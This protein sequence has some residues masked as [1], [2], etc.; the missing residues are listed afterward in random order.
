[1]LF[2]TGGMQ[3]RQ[4]CR[5]IFARRLKRFWCMS[6]K[7]LENN[8]IFQ[9]FFLKVPNDKLNAVSTTPPNNLLRRARIF[10]Q[11]QKKI[12]FSKR[13]LFLKILQKCRFDNPVKKFTTKT[14]SFFAKCPRLIK[15]IFRKIILLDLF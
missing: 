7:H 4:P 1:M 12:F 3:F 5:K 6:E 14:R 11:C 15:K 8:N 2:W 10:S 9:K 13:L